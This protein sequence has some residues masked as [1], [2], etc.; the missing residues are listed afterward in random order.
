M[1]EINSLYVHASKDL[2]TLGYIYNGDIYISTIDP[3]LQDWIHNP[4][5][6]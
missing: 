3:D 5:N 2:K 4:Y 6:L 1:G